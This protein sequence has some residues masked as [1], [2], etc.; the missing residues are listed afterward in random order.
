METMRIISESLRRMRKHWNSNF[1]VRLRANAAVDPEAGQVRYVGAVWVT[2]L[3]G[4]A[5]TINQ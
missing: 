4:N 2:R 3:C 5:K 1:R